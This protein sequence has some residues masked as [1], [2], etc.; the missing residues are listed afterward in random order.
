MIVGDYR[1]LESEEKNFKTAFDWLK[2]EAWK[3]MEVGT[4]KID[5][6]EVYAFVQ[7]YETKP[8]EAV[9]F[10]RHHHYADIQMTM[11]GHELI[12]VGQTEEETGKLTVPYKPDVE[13][14]GSNTEKADL[15]HLTPGIA[16]VLYPID[17]H[18]PGVTTDGPC[19]VRKVV[20]KIKVD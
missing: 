10:E 9:K 16:C 19:F 5:G 18:L 7:E 14:Y 8:V 12:Y 6:D 11:E 20:V 1:Y 13:F 17:A 15:V 3:T 4:V 2:G